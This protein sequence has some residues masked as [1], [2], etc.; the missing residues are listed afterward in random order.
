MRL[1]S[2]QDSKV[3]TSSELIAGNRAFLSR[4][5]LQM[6]NAETLVKYGDDQDENFFLTQ[7]IRKNR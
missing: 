7:H 3:K 4:I 2:E 1:F 6:S 5:I